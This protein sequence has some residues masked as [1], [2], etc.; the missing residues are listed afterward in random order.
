MPSLIL[1][2]SS[3][4]RRELL[5]KLG[6][7]FSHH[8]PEIDETPKP[9]EAPETLATRLALEK[10]QAIAGIYPAS[11]IIGSD[12]VASLKG[13]QLHKPGSHQQ[14][15]AQLESCSGQSVDFFTSICLLNSQT[16]K[17][18]LTVEK[19]QVQFRQLSHEQI[20]RYICAEQPYDCAGSFKMEGLGISLF[21][22]IEGDDP[23][24]LIGLPLIRLVDMLDNEGVQIP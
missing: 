6:L 8:S 14:A 13:T 23:N 15:V 3:T 16:G 20:D 7:D 11:L 9:D 18:Q 10:A 1:A 24:T 19:Y 22:K 21:T 12:Q 17:H 2:S 4:Y 5:S